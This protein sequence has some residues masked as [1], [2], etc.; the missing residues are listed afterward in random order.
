MCLVYIVSMINRKYPIGD[1]VLKV[2]Y[3]LTWGSIFL[4][5]IIYTHG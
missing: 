4:W 2:A 1:I 3:L 5:E